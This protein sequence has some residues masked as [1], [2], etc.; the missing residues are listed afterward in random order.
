MTNAEYF[1]DG[2][3]RFKRYSLDNA[4]KA[5]DM[6]NRAIAAI[7]QMNYDD[8]ISYVNAAILRIN[9]A[10]VSKEKASLLLAAAHKVA[11]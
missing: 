9:D 8:A 11:E 7:D 4:S 5:K 10:K 3:A 2:A 1:E 6:L